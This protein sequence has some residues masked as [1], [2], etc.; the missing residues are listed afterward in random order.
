MQ[1]DCIILE[2]LVLET[3]ANDCTYILFYVSDSSN[4]FC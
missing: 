1:K 3:D 4:L 2:T